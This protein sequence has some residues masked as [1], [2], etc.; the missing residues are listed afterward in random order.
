MKKVQIGSPV[1]VVDEFG[2]EHD[3]LVT[4]PWGSGP[5]GAQ[6]YDDSD[7]K[8][9]TLAINVVFVSG[10]QTKTDTYGRQTEHLSSCVHR[11][12]KGECPG[13]YWYQP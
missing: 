1:K 11:S 9:V 8:Q 10:D 13:R 4:Q 5:D 7:G 3:G 6:E 2:V 12:I